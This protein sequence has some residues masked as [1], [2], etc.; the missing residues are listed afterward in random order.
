MTVVRHLHSMPVGYSL[1]RFP[2]TW[3]LWLR[4]FMLR[5]PVVPLH[6]HGCRNDSS[7]LLHILSRLG[8]KGLLAIPCSKIVITR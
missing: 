7:E 8:E 2:E 6:L 5:C 4:I 3:F 1:V